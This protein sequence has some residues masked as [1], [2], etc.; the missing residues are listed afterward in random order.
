[1]SLDLSEAFGSNE[2]AEIAGVWI[3][4]GSGAEIRI[5]RLGN[6][7]AQRAYRTLPVRIR[8]SIEQ[9]LLDEKESLDFL[10]NFIITNII[11][12]WKGLVDGGKVMKFSTENALKMLKKH[13]RFRD[14]IWELANDDEIFNVDELEEDSK[15]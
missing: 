8:R 6:P 7:E 12:D 2:K 3:P 14:R 13:R 10:N 9:G 4:L 1:M 5:A 11:K 15:N